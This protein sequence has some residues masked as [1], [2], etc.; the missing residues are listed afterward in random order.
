MW[1]CLKMAIISN[2]ICNKCKYK[3]YWSSSNLTEKQ[4]QYRPVKKYYWKISQNC[5]IITV[6]VNVWTCVQEQIVTIYVKV[7]GLKIIVWLKHLHYRVHW[8]SYL[9]FSMCHSHL[10]GKTSCIA[11]NIYHAMNMIDCFIIFHTIS[12]CCAAFLKVNFVL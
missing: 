3:K 4:Q 8:I 5:Y 9:T 10:Y 1:T 7:H 6:L 11:I 2:A 12:C